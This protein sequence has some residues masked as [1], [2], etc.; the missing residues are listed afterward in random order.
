[1][2][3]KIIEIFMN[4]M[5]TVAIDVMSGFSF[6][7]KKLSEKIFVFLNLIF[8]VISV[9]NLFCYRSVFSYNLTAFNSTVA[10]STPYDSWFIS[11]FPAIFTVIYAFLN[12]LFSIFAHINWKSFMKLLL[13]T[14]VISIFQIIITKWIFA[15][16]SFYLVT[17]LMT[18]MVNIM[19]IISLF[20]YIYFI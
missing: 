4:R 17:L 7:N 16:N 15:V 12:L 2:F 20:S 10:S 6:S 19:G 3:N 11:I 14:V 5:Y 18:L 13:Y 9:W 1:M 8:F